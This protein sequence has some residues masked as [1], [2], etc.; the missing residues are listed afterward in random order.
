VGESLGAR[1]VGEGRWGGGKVRGAHASRGVALEG[2]AGEGGAAAKLDVNRPS[3]LPGAQGEGAAPVTEWGRARGAPGTPPW[4]R[5][6]WARGGGVAG[7]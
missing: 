6:A 3:A 1:G 4:G 2:A 7:R 5:A